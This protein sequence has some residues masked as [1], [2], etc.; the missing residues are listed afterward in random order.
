MLKLK[1]S[2]LLLNR[3][4]S[5]SPIYLSEKSK[6]YY[7]ILGVT[8]DS[9][10]SEIKKSYYKLARKYHPDANPNNPKGRVFLNK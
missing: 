10:R 8:H 9:S 5:S 4:I 6:N 2:F 3:R 7:A 1:K